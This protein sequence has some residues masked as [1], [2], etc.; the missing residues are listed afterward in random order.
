M[1]FVRSTGCNWEFR[2][3]K[4][5]PAQI[6]GNSWILVKDLSLMSTRIEQSNISNKS[7]IDI[8]ITHN[9]ARILYAMHHIQKCPRR[10]VTM[11]R[12]CHKISISERKDRR[13]Y[14]WKIDFPIDSTI[15]VRTILF[16][17]IVVPQITLKKEIVIRRMLTSI[18]RDLLCYW[19]KLLLETNNSF[20]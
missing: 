14:S 6:V 13:N 3:V 7:F 20:M 4:F 9:Y 8:K 10:H 12:S 18:L 19:E 17:D 5:D 2:A 15:P 1:F 16:D 11:Q